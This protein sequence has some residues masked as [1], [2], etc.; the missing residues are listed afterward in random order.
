MA[1]LKPL[2]DDWNAK[3][4]VIS[5][6]DM[7]HF[8]LHHVLHSMAVAKYHPFTQ[9]AQVLD[10]GTGGGFPGIP[11]AICYPETE[12]TLIDSIGKKVGV[13]NEVVA[14]LNLKNV[15]AHQLRVEEL[16]LKYD[17]IVSRAVTALPAFYDLVKKNLKPLDPKGRHGDILYLKGSDHQRELSGSMIRYK[18]IPIH[19]YFAEAFFDEK[20]I[21]HIF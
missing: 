10:V 21:V 16:N 18:A 17:H 19:T 14:A 4:N 1:K 12:F 13:V 11:L 9:G 20:Y 3:I 5:R 7:D 2:Y 15:K 6:K 8:Y